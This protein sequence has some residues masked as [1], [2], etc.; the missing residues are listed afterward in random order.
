MK[1]LICSIAAVLVASA[2]AVLYKTTAAAESGVSTAAVSRRPVLEYLQAV[3]SVAPPQDTQL[4]FL[5]MAR[6]S[7]ANLQRVPF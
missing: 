5:L 7:N 3:N 2:V 4:L 1:T 6:Y